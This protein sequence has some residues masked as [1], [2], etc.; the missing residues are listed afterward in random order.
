MK[1]MGLNDVIYNEIKER[2]INN[3]YQPGE[4]FDLDNISEELGVSRTPVSNALK[5]LEKDGYVYIAQR[6]GSYVRKY[7]VGEIEA[8][9]EFREALEGVVVKKAVKNANDDVL[10]TF[11]RKFEERFSTIE[12]G[13]APYVDEI[14]KYAEDHDEFHY[15]L[16]GLCPK[17]IRDEMCNL[18]DLTK[19]IS[20]RNVQYAMKQKYAKEY[21]KEDIETHIKLAKAII[22]RDIDRS[23]YYICK[24]I[25][26]AKDEI[27]DFF[28][29]IE[30]LD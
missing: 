29:A 6:S 1:Y 9:F 25:R 22:D 12:N 4:K 7:S 18:I 16:M 14:F 17:I 30:A 10:N 27:I 3:I 11:I 15:Y 20:K 23:Y 5:A 26:K 19:R 28:E 2:I 13:K 8:L 24:D 21:A